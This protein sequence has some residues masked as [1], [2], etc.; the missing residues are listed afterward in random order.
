MLLTMSGK[1]AILFPR[2]SFFC[3][4]S[5][6]FLSS[7]LPDGVH[8]LLRA[9]WDFEEELY[10]RFLWLRN[11]AF[12]FSAPLCGNM[13]LTVPKV[14]GMEAGNVII[15]VTHHNHRDRDGR[16]GRWGLGKTRKVSW[17]EGMAVIPEY[18]SLNPG[19]LRACGCHTTPMRILTSHEFSGL[20]CFDF[21]R[22]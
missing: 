20:C 16:S 5:S 9:S 6:L 1:R 21:S 12:G 7:T 8:G 13:L 10:L 15:L 22:H 19:E 18:C 4:W 2:I 17:E 14:F 11:S 3:F